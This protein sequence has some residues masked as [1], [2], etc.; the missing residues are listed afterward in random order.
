MKHFAPLAKAHFEKGREHFGIVVSKAT[1]L[2]EL[3]RLTINL[4]NRAK[5]E[6]LKNS[7]VWLQS[8]R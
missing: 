1:E 7:F 3:I 5:A 2:S 6:E 4:L 8:Y